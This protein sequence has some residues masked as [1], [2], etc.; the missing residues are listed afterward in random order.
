M[1]NADLDLLRQL[2]LG[3]RVLSKEKTL[4]LLGSV[5][6]KRVLVR[7]INERWGGFLCGCGQAD[8]EGYQ[9]SLV[10]TPEGEVREVARAFCADCGADKGETM[11]NVLPPRRFSA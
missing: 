10:A 1:T 9:I 8:D 4:E 3:H 2:E 5:P 7:N 6:E 11:N